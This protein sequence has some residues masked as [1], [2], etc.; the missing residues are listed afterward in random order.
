MVIRRDLLPVYPQ[1][2]EYTQDSFYKRCELGCEWDFITDI[3]W[4]H[5]VCCSLLKNNELHRSDQADQLYELLSEYQAASENL[6]IQ[7]HG[8]H[9]HVQFRNVHSHI[10]MCNN[11]SSSMVDND[12]L[13][14]FLQRKPTS[15]I[16]WP[17]SENNLLSTYPSDDAN[18]MKNILKECRPSS[19]QNIS[20]GNR[21]QATIIKH[22]NNIDFLPWKRLLL[23]QEE[24]FNAE[25]V[26]LDKS[27]SLSSFPNNIK[28]LSKQ[29]SLSHL[30]NVMNKSFSTSDNRSKKFTSSSTSNFSSSSSTSRQQQSSSISSSVSTTTC[31]HSTLISSSRKRS[32]PPT[33]L[34]SNSC[35]KFKL[36]Q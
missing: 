23:S 21:S 14:Y 20:S 10:D 12:N 25:F 29:N 24:I 35:K 31:D 27:S 22:D 15:Y 17:Y 36:K 8:V 11:D 30:S 13:N 1:P 6:K 26:N 16:N 34:F 19:V 3:P 33:K 5:E 28:P 7:R 32:L 18:T 2:M 4:V 9:Y